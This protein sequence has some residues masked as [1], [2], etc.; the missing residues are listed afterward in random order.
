MK[1]S[2]FSSG[3]YKSLD[4]RSVEM[5]T[6][7]EFQEIGFHMQRIHQDNDQFIYKLSWDILEL[8]YFSFI[9]YH[10]IYYSNLGL[11]KIIEIKEKDAY[12][13][14]SKTYE[15]LHKEYNSY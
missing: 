3:I 1:K 10:D 7:K 2:E 12:E 11:E 9:S 15:L 14:L 5:I 6:F 13:N 8:S 4:K